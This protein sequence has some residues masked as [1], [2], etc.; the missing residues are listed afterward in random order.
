[1][2]NFVHI[3]KELQLECSKRIF[4][5]LLF[6]RKKQMNIFCARHT[7]A[8]FLYFVYVQNHKNSEKINKNRNK[9]QKM[10]CV[11]LREFIKMSKMVFGAKVNKNKII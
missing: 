1:M 3:F 11:F 4:F 6:N 2:K 8:M 9:V 10:E 5:Y 7:K